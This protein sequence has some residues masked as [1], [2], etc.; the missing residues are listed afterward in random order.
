MLVLQAE[1]K[2]LEGGD[3]KEVHAIISRLILDT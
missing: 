2:M 3:N 1:K